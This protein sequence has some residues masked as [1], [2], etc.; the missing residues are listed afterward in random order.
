MEMPV[1]SDATLLLYLG[2]ML[3]PPAAA[4]IDDRLAVDPG[5]RH[6][7]EACS[8][9]LDAPTPHSLSMPTGPSAP[10]LA[11]ELPLAMDNRLRIGSGYR[12]TLPAPDERAREVVLLVWRD[13]WQMASPRRATERCSLSDLPRVDGRPVLDVRATGP[14]GEQHWRIAL[15]E[16]G[17]MPWPADGQTEEVSVKRDASRRLRR[18]RG[19]IRQ[20]SAPTFDYTV[21][22][23]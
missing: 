3:D 15:P 19:A 9:R 7:L 14:R 1:I 13:G 10:R 16:I 6:R 21:T 12:L 5:L 4:E 8:R 20:G 18:V 23:Y 22:V 11:V 17:L 2:G